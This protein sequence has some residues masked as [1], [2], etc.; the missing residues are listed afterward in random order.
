MGQG[1]RA[2]HAKRAGICLA[3]AFVVYSCS[4]PQRSVVGA[5][6]RDDGC[7]YGAATNAFLIERA[8]SGTYKITMY[9]PRVSGYPLERVIEG[10]FR[11]DTGRPTVAEP[12]WNHESM[13]FLP[14]AEKI[15]YEECYYSHTSLAVLQQAADAA[16]SAE[17][18]EAERNAQEAIRLAEQARMA[19]A[20]EIRCRTLFEDSQ[21]STKTIAT[22]PGVRITDTG[23]QREPPYQFELPRGPLWFGILFEPESEIREID[24][25]PYHPS[26][27][28]VFQVRIVHLWDQQRAISRPVLASEI[29]AGGSLMTFEIVFNTRD[30]AA[31]FIDAVKSARS[32]W[33]N[34]W[35]ELFSCR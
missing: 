17:R 5:W 10:I 13:V 23:I 8:G 31:R 4:S 25:R 35:N 7:R 1:A 6:M 21:K 11:E 14:E 34:K 9:E 30:E 28:R 27:R 16:R 19:Q 20:A 3:T 15:V 32:E 18:A 2:A 24:S 12:G 29:Q 22:F 33:R 26:S